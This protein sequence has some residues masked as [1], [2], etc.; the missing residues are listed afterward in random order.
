[1]LKQFKASF[2]EGIIQ[3]QNIIEILFIENLIEN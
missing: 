1:M 2:T 3:M